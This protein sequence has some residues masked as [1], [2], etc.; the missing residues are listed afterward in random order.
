MQMGRFMLMKKKKKKKKKKNVPRGL[1]PQ[2]RGYIHV[3]DYNIQTSSNISETA[4]PLK[5]KLHEE[6]R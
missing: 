2:S 5:D 4:L 6:H 1:S 3:Y